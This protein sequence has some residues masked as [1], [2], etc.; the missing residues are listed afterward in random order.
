M[1]GMDNT[2]YTITKVTAAA[3]TMTTNDS[4]LLC[5][6]SGGAITIT[7]PQAGAD[8]QSGRPFF[9][10]TTGTTNSVTITPTTSTIDGGATLVLAS[11]AVHGVMFVSDG[12]NY[13]S[14]VKS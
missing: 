12:T 11:G 6:P 9:V 13:F 8:W 4:V 10:R 1:S 14:I 2:S 7:V 5:D 3:Y